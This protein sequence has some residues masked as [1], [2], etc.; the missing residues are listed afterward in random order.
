MNMMKSKYERAESLLSWNLATKLKNVLVEPYWLDD[1]RFWFKRDL[2]IGYEFILVDSENVTQSPLFEHKR[3]ASALANLFD[4]DIDPKQLPI[5]MIEFH[6]NRMLRLIIESEF[7]TETRVWIDLNDYGCSIE[8]NTHPAKINED[9]LSVVSPD[10]QYKVISRDNNLYLCEVLTG[11]ERALTEDGEPHYGYGNYTD[12]RAIGIFEKKP[13]R[14]AVIWSPNGRY[15]A[16]QRI[17]ER[18]VD[19]MPIALNVPND[20]SVRPIH[21]TYKCAL[22]GDETVG[23]ATVCVINI[24]NNQ[25][26]YCDRPPA[27]TSIISPIESDSI[28]WG[29]DNLVYFIESS[30][31]DKTVHLICLDPLTGLSRVLLKEQGVGHVFPSALPCGP[32]VIQILP[33][34]MEFVWYSNRS[35]WGHLY[36]YDLSTGALKNP[37]TSGEFVVTKIH[38]ISIQNQILCFSACGRESNRDPYYEHIYRINFDGTDLVLLTP[39]AS[40]HEVI[41]PTTWNATAAPR[42]NLHGFSPS[43]KVFVDTISRVDQP[44]RSVLRSAIDGA[45]MMV[46]SQCDVTEFEDTVYRMPFPFSVIAADGKSE[47]WG[48]IYRPSD[49]DETQ[50][51]PVVL[52]IYG[53]PQMCVTPKRFGELWG[54]IGADIYQAMAE[55]GF[56]IIVMDPRGTP[57]RSKAYLDVAYGNM[58]NGGGI[59]D[60][61]GALKQLGEL[62]LWID[63]DRVGITGHS[64]G[65]FASAR[66]ML[67]HPDFFKVAVSSAGNHDQRLYVTAWGDRFQGLLEDNNYQL[68]ACSSLAENLQGRLLLVHGDKDANVN[69]AHTMQLVDKLIEHNKNFDLLILPNRQHVYFHDTY[70]IRRLWDYFVEHLLGETPP[71][72]YRIAN[73]KIDSPFN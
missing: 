21:Y 48:V 17:D 35:G 65:G 22:P 54:P 26:I 18:Y 11:E 16:V 3:L 62:Y 71:K 9:L 50:K 53:G 56:V 12:F 42:S 36:R 24:Q 25:I 60:Q 47:V 41:L 44:S 37:I 72:D 55:L 59:E 31:D 29:I 57:L 1:Q 43:G 34:V 32:P 27:P 2:K 23:L 73:G 61:V 7:S 15:L 67:S 33:E 6:S 40:Q 49:F 51:Y 13:L 28:W 4:Q 68:Q 69:I 30:R 52:Y 63:L 14:S 20:G 66:A 45:E 39:E 8:A 10:G 5:E 58:Q 19:D 70:Y 38:H 46:L 64:G